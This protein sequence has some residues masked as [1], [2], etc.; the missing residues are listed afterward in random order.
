M[1]RT[2]IEARMIALM[3]LRMFARVPLGGLNGNLD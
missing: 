1:E 2:Q 3:T